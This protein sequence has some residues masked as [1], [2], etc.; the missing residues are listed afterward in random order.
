[1][2]NFKKL[3]AVAIAT[4]LF[5]TAGVAYAAAVKT[6]AEITSELTGKTVEELSSER[7]VG[8]TYGTIANE[9]GKLEEFKAQML[10]QKKAILDQ[11]VKDGR[12]T[13]EQADEIYNSMKNNQ[14][15]CD[16]TGSAGMGKRSGAGFGQGNGMGKGQGGRGGAGSC[17]GG[18]MGAGSGLNR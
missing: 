4:G 10:E 11:R 2:R 8:K 18:G 1:M 3:A 5:A 14:A 15:A 6:P 16:G 13:Q 7:A 17:N 12:L 9:A